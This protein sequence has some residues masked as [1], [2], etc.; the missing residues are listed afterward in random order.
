MPSWDLRRNKTK[1]P[2][3]IVKLTFELWETEKNSNVVMI[4]QQ[5]ISYV[6]KKKGKAKLSRGDR[7]YGCVWGG[8]GGW[9]YV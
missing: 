3:P 9:W 5:I 2:L 7:E 8:T 6:K 1:V 4:N